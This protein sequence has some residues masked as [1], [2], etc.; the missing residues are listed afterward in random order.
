MLV[1]GSVTFQSSFQGFLYEFKR[2]TPLSMSFPSRLLRSR[3]I[4]NCHAIGDANRL[5][6]VL[7]LIGVN[8][9]Q[10]S[11]TC[12]GHGG[13]ETMVHVGSCWFDGRKSIDLAG[14]VGCFFSHY[15]VFE[16]LQHTLYNIKTHQKT[17]RIKM[18]KLSKTHEKDAL[19][20]WS[21]GGFQTPRFFRTLMS[22]LL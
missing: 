10:I 17:C 15:W 11:T 13:F 8:I 18:K 21:H 3:A 19:L 12:A 7:V 1:S 9:K 20:L 16:M 5:G 4:R 2:K 6:G 14:I 22:S